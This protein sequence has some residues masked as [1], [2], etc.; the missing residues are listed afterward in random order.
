MLK[1]GCRLM[2]VN[3]KMKL[4][5][6]MSL[7]ALYY[8]T[9]II[10]GV[11][12]RACPTGQRSKCEYGQPTKTHYTYHTNPEEP[13]KLEV[14]EFFKEKIDNLTVVEQINELK[15]EIKKLR[16]QLYEISKKS[17]VKME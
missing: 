6:L 7:L 10:A 16:K 9:P 5:L 4:R 1:G 3:F 8:T 11:T 2:Q 14:E 12:A 15:K 13:W 17:T